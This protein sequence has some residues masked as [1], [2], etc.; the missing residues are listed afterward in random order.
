M[1]SNLLIS[2]FDLLNLRF[3]MELKDLRFRISDADGNYCKE[4]CMNQRSIILYQNDVKIILDEEAKIWRVRYYCREIVITT[5]ENTGKG[6]LTEIV[7]FYNNRMVA[8]FELLEYQ[9]RKE[10]F[11]ADDPE[12]DDVLKKIYFTV[13]NHTRMEEYYFENSISITAGLLLENLEAKEIHV[14]Y[15]MGLFFRILP[16][17]KHISK[18]ERRCH[19]Y[20]GTRRIE[21]C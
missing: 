8:I 20:P 14:Y 21:E 11:E 15:G 1:V 17:R 12:F 2:A 16:G 4:Y 10:L 19:L 18:I 6:P 3:H 7:L 9:F 5:W 13:L